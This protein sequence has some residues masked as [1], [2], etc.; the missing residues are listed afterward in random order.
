MEATKV[1]AKC[2]GYGILAIITSISL[3][4][5]VAIYLRS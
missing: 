2:V 1:I 3:G 5:L 4:Y